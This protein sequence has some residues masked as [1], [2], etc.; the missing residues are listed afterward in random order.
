MTEEE[1]EGI[2]EEV[3]EEEIDSDEGEKGD[4]PE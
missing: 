1:E 4:A 3:V 2:K